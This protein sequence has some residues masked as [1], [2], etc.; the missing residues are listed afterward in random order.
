MSPSCALFGLRKADICLRAVI[1]AKNGK[2]IAAVKVVIPLFMSDFLGQPNEGDSI[3]NGCYS[4]Y[5]CL[6]FQP[7]EKGGG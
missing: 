4:P 2:G 5:S 3:R 6:I 7:G 1:P